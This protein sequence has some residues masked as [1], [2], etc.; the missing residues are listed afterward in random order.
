MIVNATIQQYCF[1]NRL[2]DDPPRCVATNKEYI[3]FYFASE[4]THGSSNEGQAKGRLPVCAQIMFFDH[5]SNK[6]LTYK[7]Y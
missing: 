2:W 4:D 6:V 7:D 5:T 1:S 3:K